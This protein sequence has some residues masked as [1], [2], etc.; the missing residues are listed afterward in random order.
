M[1]LRLSLTR[2]KIHV[3]C[4]IRSFLDIILITLSYRDYY[5][6]ALIYNETLAGKLKTIKKKVNIYLD[7]IRSNDII[8][9]CRFQ[10]K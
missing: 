2:Y 6:E 4:I 8:M 7:Y 5:H 10:Y 9:P 1:S 3:S